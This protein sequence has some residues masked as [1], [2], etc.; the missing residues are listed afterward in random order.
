METEP[1]E[2]PGSPIGVPAR[3]PTFDVEIQD[4][5]GRLDRST[6]DWL[7][8]HVAS[9]AGELACAGE[10][11]VR[12]VGDAEMRAAHARHLGEDSTTDVLTFDLREN[13]E[14]G[15]PLDVDVLVC[16]DEAERQ[17]GERGHPASHELLLY[18]VH[19]MLHCLGYDDRD[20]A[21]FAAMHARED[22]VLGAIGVGLVYGATQRAGGAR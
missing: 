13:A 21:S 4:A 1:T 10:V 18:I 12:A 19:A 2:P 7:R 11:R 17:G 20:E 9:A 8:R 6:L 22:E 5:T 3:Q 15:A 14:G 16:V